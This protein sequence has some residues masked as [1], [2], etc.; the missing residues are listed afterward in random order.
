MLL[1]EG[2]EDLWGGA[3]AVGGEGSEGLVDHVEEGGEVGLLGVDVED[4]GEDFAGV[5]V[6]EEEVEGALA[7]GGVVVLVDL[8][9]AHVGAVVEF[10]VDGG[11]GV[12]VDVD[13]LELGDEADL[14]DGLFVVLHVFVAF[15]GALVVV[16]GDARG[17]H[18]EEHRPAVGDGGFEHGG[19]LFLIA[20]EG[21]PDEGGTHLD[22]EG[23][24]VDGREVVDDAGFE[25]GADVGGGGELAFGEAVD[26]VVFDDVDHGEVAAH[27]VDELTDADGGCVAVTGDA[28]GVHGFVGEESAGGDRG[29]AAVDGVE[30]EGAGH[31]VGG[32]F[33]GAADAAHLHDALGLDAHVVEGFEDALGDDVVAAA[34]A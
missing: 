28:D 13:V 16:E 20:G 24:D 12:V 32:G 1:H 18:I 15:G 21:A 23:A 8:A 3:D 34:G 31:E 5:F 25:L 2:F 11:V 7:A 4:A 10:D 17:D 6:A 33:G 29:H 22:G 30:A 19:E 27:E 9:E 26:A 14:G